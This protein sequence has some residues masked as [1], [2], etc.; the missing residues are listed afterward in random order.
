[1]QQFDAMKA[2]MSRILDLIPF[3]EDP[4]AEEKREI[5]GKAIAEFVE[6]FP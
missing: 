4:E 3:V 1:M 6:R 5:V 2:E